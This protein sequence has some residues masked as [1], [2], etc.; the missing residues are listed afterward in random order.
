MRK[1]K[2]HIVLFFLVFFILIKISGLHAF[3]HLENVTEKECDVCE[4]AIH[5]NNTAFLVKN[6]ISVTHIIINNYKEPSCYGYLYLFV[7]NYTDNSL[8]CR[9][10]PVI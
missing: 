4:Y 6:L 1:L 10:P 7:K 8:F 2:Q 5:A 9:P 3:I